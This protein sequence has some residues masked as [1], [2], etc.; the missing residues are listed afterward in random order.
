[1][2]KGLKVFLIVIGCILALALIGGG[3]AF[4]AVGNAADADEYKLGDDV[5]RSVKAVVEK[6][7]ISSISTETSNG[8]QT[9]TI[10]YKSPNVQEDLV[11]YVEYLRTDGGFSLTQDMD[12]SVSPASVQLAKESVDEGKIII[13]TINYDSFG[14]TM[15]IQKGEG[16]FS[17]NG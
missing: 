5:I 17:L 7:D 13:F 10:Q 3:I 6:R 2:K 9:K 11:R 8:V 15:I 12:L 4:F 1:M 16:T 14:Y